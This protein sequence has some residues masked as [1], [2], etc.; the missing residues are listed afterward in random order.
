MTAE[1]NYS[2][3]EENLDLVF[4]NIEDIEQKLFTYKHHIQQTK[5]SLQSDSVEKMKFK[6]RLDGIKNGVLAVQEKAR[7]G[8]G[9]DIMNINNHEKLMQ[10]EQSLGEIRTTIRNLRGNE[11]K[12]RRDIKKKDDIIKDFNTT[13]RHVQQQINQYKQ[14]IHLYQEKTNY[15]THTLEKSRHAIKGDRLKADRKAQNLKE[16]FE[17]SQLELMETLEQRESILINHQNHVDSLNRRLEEKKRMIGMFQ[18]KELELKKMIEEKNK[19]IAALEREKREFPQNDH[20]WAVLEEK[21]Y[22]QGHDGLHTMRRGRWIRMVWSLWSKDNEV[23]YLEKI[24]QLNNTIKDLQQGLEYN[25]SI[26][27]K[28]NS[29]FQRYE[30]NEIKYSEQI[31]ELHDKLQSFQDKEGAYVR[32][33]EQIEDELSKYKKENVSYQEQVETM[34]ETIKKLQDK[35]TEY[36][37]KLDQMKRQNAQNAQQLNKAMQSFEEKERQYR[38]QFQ[39]TLNYPQGKSVSERPTNNQAMIKSGRQ[40]NNQAIVQSGRQ[41]SNQAMAQSRRQTNNQ[42][43]ES[44]NKR[45]LKAAE[46]IKQFYP[47]SQS[48]S[49][50]S[51]FNPFKYS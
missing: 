44:T 49:Q 34:S 12:L 38:E 41:T 47:Q 33:L 17:E 8:C 28:M 1:K 42:T 5:I 48:H 4:L 29:Y 51:I 2:D 13:Q 9:T 37:S 45:N 40:P 16:L 11:G 39:R 26:L 27:E 32:K 18:Q 10:L 31:K 6:Q 19:I 14:T 25:E 15:L 35:E 23:E 20:N 43:K 50:M 3:Q 7:S 22:K 21:E 24:E 36:K 30:E 46:M